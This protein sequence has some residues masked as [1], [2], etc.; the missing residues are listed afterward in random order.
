MPSAF[1]T[2]VVTG[3]SRGMGLAVARQLA[4]KGANVVIVA[5]DQ[6]K[7][8]DSLSYVKADAANK[9]NQ[10][11]HQISADLTSSSEAVRVL[12]EVAS[13][14]GGIP[15]D[16]VWCCAG[17]SHPTLFVDTPVSEFS[18]QM[19]HNYFTALYMAHATLRQWLP[20]EHSVEK[21]GA[22]PSKP[23]PARH[24]IFTASFLAFYS[25]TGY[26]PYS[27]CKAA[28]RSL[29]DTLSQEVNMYAA[30]NPSQPKV[31]LHT[32]FPAGILT[33]GFEAENRIKPDV[34]KLL[35][36]GDKPLTPELIAS[37]SIKGLESG[38]ELITTDFQTGL[39]GR[40]M[41]G[42]SVR[43]GFVRGLVDWMLASLL[44]VVMVFV[45]GDMDKKVR[46]WGTKFGVSGMKPG[47]NS[48]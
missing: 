9:S 25:F 46:D 1:E 45:R 27:P 6:A 40:S 4:E 8:L 22:P 44:V 14:N 10:R 15:P 48:A 5:R 23:A 24:L 19:N 17:S 37:R 31:R 30:A 32:I 11:F 16:I 39:V 33:E 21:P 43:G 3:G 47:R 41:L 42:G 20:R 7:L 12:D 29:S 2:A 28:L 36:A 34:T 35:E 18:T 26:S 13:W 38:Q